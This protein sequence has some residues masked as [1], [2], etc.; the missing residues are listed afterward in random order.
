MTG[1]AEVTPRD[2]R[3][4]DKPGVEDAKVYRVRYIPICH[5]STC[6]T[7]DTILSLR[8]YPKL[9][10]R[11]NAGMAPIHPCDL[12]SQSFAHSSTRSISVGGWHTLSS[13]AVKPEK[14]RRSSS[15]NLA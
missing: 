11:A 10:V 7:L 1:N 13:T 9:A 14:L 15:V 12:P 6:A 3:L 2:F 4:A 8:V 5:A